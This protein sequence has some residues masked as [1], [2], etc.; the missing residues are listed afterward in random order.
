MI[1]RDF[2]YTDCGHRTLRGS[3]ILFPRHYLAL[4][5]GVTERSNGAREGPVTVVVTGEKVKTPGEK[6]NHN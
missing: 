2:G 1:I 4:L 5:R 6:G 3:L